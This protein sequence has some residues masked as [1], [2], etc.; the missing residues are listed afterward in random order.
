MDG[1]LELYDILANSER[2]VAFT[3]AGFSVP[4]GI[5]D[6]RSAGGIYDGGDFMGH[7]PEYM[8]SHDCLESHPE[9]F[10][11]FYRRNMICE[12]ARPN[13][14]H[15]LLAALEADGRLR[16]VVTQNIDGLHGDAGSKRVWELHGSVRRNYCVNCG[17]R[18]GL[19]AVTGT[20]GVPRCAKCGGMIRP[21][22]VLYGEGLDT[23]TVEGAEADIAEADTLLVAGTSLT[24]YPAASLVYM[25]EGENLVLLNKSATGGDGIATLVLHEDIG[26]AAEELMRLFGY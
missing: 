19:D 8:L 11:E 20:E 24:V 15:M 23:F 6:F 2:T 1:I 7:S 26:K 5:P 9:E 12:D 13:A 3:G 25:F 16:S 14:A 18:Y 21:D 4:S 10:Y 17:A 22:V